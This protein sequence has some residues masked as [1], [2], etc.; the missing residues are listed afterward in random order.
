MKIWPTLHLNHNPFVNSRAISPSA[1]FTSARL[2]QFNTEWRRHAANGRQTTQVTHEKPDR[3]WTS[4]AVCQQWLSKSLT[5]Q[6]QGN[7]TE[8][9]NQCYDL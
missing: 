5:E 8:Q 7:D 9:L 2:Q 4:S 1:T 3:K 6:G